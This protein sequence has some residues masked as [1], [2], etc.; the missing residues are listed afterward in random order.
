[1]SEGSRW[2]VQPLDFT[3]SLSVS[4]SCADIW[5]CFDLLSVSFVKSE[6]WGLTF[7]LI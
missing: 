2:Q 4:V 6:K 1:M 5:G 7:T 3:V